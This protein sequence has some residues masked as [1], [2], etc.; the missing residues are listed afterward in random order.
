MVKRTRFLTLA[1]LMAFPGS[2]CQG[3]EY[4]YRW[5]YVSKSLGRD[6]DVADIKGIVKTASESGLNGMV[7]AAG[8]DRLDRFHQ[9]F[10]AGHLFPRRPIQHAQGHNTPLQG[11]AKRVNPGAPAIGLR[12]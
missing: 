1:L 7:L 10:R 2:L 11:P 4:P 6:S 9:C 5:V 12:P 3:K 8:L